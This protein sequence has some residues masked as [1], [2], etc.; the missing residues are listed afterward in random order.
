[1]RA[2]R[3]GLACATYAGLGWI[4]GETS[5]RAE[6]PSIRSAPWELRIAGG[7]E[8][9]ETRFGIFDLG[10]RKGPLSIQLFTDTLDVRYAPE[11]SRGRWWIAARAETFAA[12]LMISPWT[13]GAPDPSRALTAAYLGAEGGGV[14][15]LPGGL[16]VGGQAM[17]RLYLF[18][19]QPATT[20]EVPGPTPVFT[21]DAVLGHYTPASHVWVRGGFDVELG[22]VQPHI[23]LEATVRPDWAFA[24][25]V[26]VRG[27]WARNQDFITRTRLGGLNPYVVP[28]AGA[29][30][31]EFWVES[32]LALRAG[33]SL[34]IPLPRRGRL[35]GSPH[36]LELSAVGD[37]AGFDGRIEAGFG[38]LTR[39]RYARYSLDASLGYAPWLRRREG[40]P[41]LAGFLLFS[42]DWS[43]LRRKK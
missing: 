19:G 25:R 9:S 37:V 38:L 36:T 8:V 2:L 10:L 26:E 35:T 34:R 40:I 22:P 4:F 21:V 27:A 41:A 23:A 31:A 30:W 14:A 18:F 11:R 29:G 20:I 7:G 12:G 6:S 15:Y 3:I 33:P 32:Y 24:P 1:M 28:L 16:Y 42:V 5:A 17:A 39:W 43:P 13:D